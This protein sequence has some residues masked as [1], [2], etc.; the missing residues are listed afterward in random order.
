L[1]YK[2]ADRIKLKQCKATELEKSILV[3]WRYK[4]WY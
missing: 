1:L 4:T 2:E 3:R